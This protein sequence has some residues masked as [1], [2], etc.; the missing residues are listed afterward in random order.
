M[1]SGPVYE[2]EYPHG[3]GKALLDVEV[4]A[5]QC[6]YGLVEHDD[7]GEERYECLGLQRALAYPVGRV[8]DGYREGEGPQGLHQGRGEGAH[9]YG[10]YLVSGIGLVLLLEAG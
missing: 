6:L 3:R 1:L 9:L 4:H 5:V 2:L 8:P 10:L 7:G